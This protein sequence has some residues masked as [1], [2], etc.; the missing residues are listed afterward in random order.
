MSSIFLCLRRLSTTKGV[1]N[2]DVIDKLGEYYHFNDTICIA[3]WG[4]TKSTLGQYS[5]EYT[6]FNNLFVDLQR[7]QIAMINFYGVPQGCK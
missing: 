7:L 4:K 2:S 3:G 6:E 5:F 1:S